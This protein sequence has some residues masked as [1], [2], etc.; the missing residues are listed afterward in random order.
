MLEGGNKMRR[1]KTLYLFLTFLLVFSFLG[2]GSTKGTAA[3]RN[4]LT[5]GGFETDFGEDK[6]WTVDAD[7]DNIEIERMP[8]ADDEWITSDEGLYVLKYWIADT[9]AESKEFTINQTLAR[10]E[11]RRVGKEGRDRVEQAV[12]KR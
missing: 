2:I 1:I 3:P 12:M 9:A 6:T 4:L 10:S 5:N 7:W 8:Y 11:E